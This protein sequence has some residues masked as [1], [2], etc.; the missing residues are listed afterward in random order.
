MVMSAANHLN[1]LKARSLLKLLDSDVSPLQSGSVLG[2]YVLICGGQSVTG[3]DLLSSS[4]LFPSEYYSTRAPYSLILSF[5]TDALC[6]QQF[7]TST[8]NTVAKPS[9]LILCCDIPFGQWIGILSEK[10]N[11]IEQNPCLRERCDR[12]SDELR[13]FSFH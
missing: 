1:Q 4:L 7:T 5:F 13:N 9:Y 3:L 12:R 2:R 8:I 6:L 11:L 10:F